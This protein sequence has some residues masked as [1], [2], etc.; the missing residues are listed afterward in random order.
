VREEGCSSR[1]ENNFFTEM[2]SAS[3]AGS[4][5]RLIDFVYHSTRVMK[6]KGAAAHPRVSSSSPGPM[7]VLGG[8]VVSYE[9]GTPVGYGR[10]P[11]GF[12]FFPVRDTCPDERHLY[13]Y[14][15]I[16]ICM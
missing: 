9:R 2:C 7:A 13:I 12:F 14:I 16:Y 6:K 3:E 5:L 11:A 8:W 10:S 15:Y 4:F 1:F